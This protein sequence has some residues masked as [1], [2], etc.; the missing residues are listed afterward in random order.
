MAGPESVSRKSP[1]KEKVIGYNIIF[2]TVQSKHHMLDK[3][4]G[5]YHRLKKKIYNN[6]RSKKFGLTFPLPH[7]VTQ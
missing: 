1:N 5:I 3:E 4:N 2:W 7:A 6:K